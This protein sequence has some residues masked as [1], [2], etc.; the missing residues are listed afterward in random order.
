[1]E[2]SE[3][4]THSAIDAPDLTELVHGSGPFLS[5]YLNTEPDVERASQ[6][7]QT[8]WKT[9]RSDLEQQ[10]VSQH[11]L[12]EIE[13]LVPEAH[14]QGKCLAVIGGAE[15]V[16]H[17][18]H[19]PTVSPSD[20]AAVGPI[21]QLLP[22]VRWRQV[23][24]PYVVVLI[25]RRGADLFGIRRG[26]PDLETE[27]QGDHD[28]LRKVGPGGWSQRRF[29]QRAEDSWE[30]NAEQVA[31][32]VER[33][34]VQIQPAFV[35]VAG[36]VRSVQ[37]LRDSLSREVDALLQVIDGERPWDG[38]GDPIPEEVHE[39][40][41]GTVREAT[42]DLLDRFDQELGQQD[43]A[44]EGVEATARA[45]AR[46]QVATLLIADRT[47][48]DRS[49]WFGPDPALLATTEQELKGLGVD[50]P[51]EGSARDVLLRAALATGAGLWVVEG[52]DRFR[53]GVGALLR[54]SA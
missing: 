34:V 24:P 53:A 33:I 43:K 6:R 12:D 37:L 1:M 15:Q 45:L 2:T 23:E 44:T 4:F 36:D 30:Q 19:G 32:A 11:L 41:E 18:E 28:E 9:V 26:S 5:L 42:E 21:P 50:S 39:L 35:A 10:E 46:A 14:L 52:V 8:G 51:E 54:W 27:V 16:L 20:E 22:I 17:V 48:D 49:L 3:R 40:V 38:K 25:D 13:L 47:E 29:R 31:A 7:S